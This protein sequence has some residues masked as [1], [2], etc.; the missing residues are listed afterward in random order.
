[1][2]KDIPFER[3][4]ASH[5]RANCWSDKNEENPR[6]VFKSSGK[7]IWFDCDKCC[8]DF[9]KSL[10][11]VTNGGGHWCSYCANQKLCKNEECKT[12]FDKSF[13]SHP[14]IFFLIYY[15]IMTKHMII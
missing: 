10:A 9:D 11:N 15:R 3:S 7:K 14:L 12:C 2:K 4:F 13:A 5:P 6:N 8:H 1:M